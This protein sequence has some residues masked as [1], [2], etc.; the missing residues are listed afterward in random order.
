V[1]RG[2]SLLLTTHYLEEADALADRVVILQRGRIIA[3]G[4]PA[5]IKARVG[6]Q[7]IRCVTSLPS[8]EI[9]GLPGVRSLRR[10]GPSVVVLAADA[11]SVARVLLVRDATLSGLEISRAN[12]EEAFVELTGSAPN[13]ASDLE[14]A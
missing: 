2:R 11:E 8:E 3:D 5:E 14:V 9:A 6:G 13:A 10:D 7:Q 1:S 12:L 4:T